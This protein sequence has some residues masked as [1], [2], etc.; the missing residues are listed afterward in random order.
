MNELEIDVGNSFCKWRLRSAEQVFASDK[1]DLN[2]LPQM[3]AQIKSQPVAQVKVCSVASVVFN[4]KLKQEIVNIWSVKP[5]FFTVSA[6][7]AGLKNSYA[8]PGKMGADRWLASIAATNKFPNTRLCIADCGSAVN[9]EFISATGEHIGGYIVPGLLMMQR[10]LLKNTAKVD[11][12]DQQKCTKPG[13][14]TGAN[15]AN[16]CLVTVLALVERLQ[17]QMIEEDGILILTGGDAEMLQPF[18]KNQ[19][20]VYIKDLVLDGFAYLD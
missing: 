15:V 3:F 7:R 17:R 4:E 2:N 20:V 13:I 10:A 9:V 8:V 14:S 18:L 19:S 6:Y 16:G 12:A 1:V 11:C 5:E